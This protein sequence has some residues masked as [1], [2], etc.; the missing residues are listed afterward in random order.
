VIGDNH[1]PT[2]GG[3]AFPL[4][5]AGGVAE[6]EVIEHLLD[7]I[8]S[9]KVGPSGGELLE[10]PFVKQQAQDFGERFGEQ[11][12]LLAEIRVAVLQKGLD[13]EHGV[14]PQDGGTLRGEFDSI[15]TGQRETSEWEMGDGAFPSPV[16]R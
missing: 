6:L 3:N 15:V 8:K 10:F 11:W 7:K 16:S 9:P 4:V 12:P 13:I 14:P 1:H 2:A 5:V